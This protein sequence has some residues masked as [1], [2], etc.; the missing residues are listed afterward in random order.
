MLL[1]GHWANTYP[2]KYIYTRILDIFFI[3]QKNV[4]LR[5][6][7]INEDNISNFFKAIYLIF[8]AFP[9]CCEE[10]QH[11]IQYCSKTIK[12]CISDYNLLN[13]TEKVIDRM[14]LFIEKVIVKSDYQNK[15][16]M[17]IKY[18]KNN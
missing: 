15:N 5:T 16:T 2:L 6:I 4:D 1:I 3:L 11:F 12:Y 10:F 13:F 17:L 8:K 18:N 7:F 9:K 14:T